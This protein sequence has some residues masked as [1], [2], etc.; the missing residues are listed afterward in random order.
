MKKISY[1]F[2]TVLLLGLFA[3][4]GCD[5]DDDP[6]PEQL[7]LQKIAKTW[8]V[9]SVNLD[10][11]DVTA[12]SYTNFTIQFTDDKRFITENGEPL[13]VGSGFWDFGTNNLDVVVI[14]GIN[15]T[16]NF[17]DEATTLQL[18]FTAN[19]NTIGGRTEG[20]S[21]SYVFNLVAQ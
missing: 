11:F 10:D 21:G 9:Q 2:S 16:T 3:T 7:Q 6:T 14:D 19:G 1:I 5:G 4:L 18:T 17:N 8:S 20:L 13:F 15:I 12:P